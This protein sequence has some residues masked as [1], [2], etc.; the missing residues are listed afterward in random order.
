MHKVLISTY[1]YMWGGD[2]R[3]AGSGSASKAARPPNTLEY[4]GLLPHI[5][6]VI[7]AHSHVCVCVCVCLCV[8]VTRLKE[9]D[10]TTNR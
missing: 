5:R 8:C 4:W 6:K 9:S 1:I 2:R 10:P 3:G 7:S